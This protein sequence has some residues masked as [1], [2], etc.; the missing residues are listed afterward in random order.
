MRHEIG[1][2]LTLFHDCEVCKNTK[3]SFQEHGLWKKT[4]LDADGV[5][6]FNSFDFLDGGLYDQNSNDARLQ[7]ERA[8]LCMPAKG[9]MPSTTNEFDLYHFN[10]RLGK[11]LNLNRRRNTPSS[12][13]ISGFNE[14]SDS[15]YVSIP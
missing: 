3:V 15:Y 12:R 14:N 9:W 8:N 1:H 11:N 5:D 10:D 2:A 4:V 13:P 6:R 7:N